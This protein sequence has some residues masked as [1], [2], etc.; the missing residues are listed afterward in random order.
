MPGSSRMKSQARGTAHSRIIRP[1][2]VQL[3]LQLVAC[4]RYIPNGTSSKLPIEEPAAPMLITVALLRT[5]HL[6]S[7]APRLT[8][9]PPAAVEKTIPNMNIRNRI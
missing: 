6:E 4:I 2:A 3:T 9:A 8:R 1:K 5:N 7:K